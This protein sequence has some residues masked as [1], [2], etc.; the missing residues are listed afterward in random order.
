MK[1]KYNKNSVIERIEIKELLIIKYGSKCSQL[2]GH[3]CGKLFHSFDLTI[4]HI[5]PI[6]RKG[7]DNFEN[8]QLLCNE[9]HY[10]KTYLENIG[11]K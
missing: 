10:T 2:N 11:V 6:N 4:D 1:P 3:G 9:C 8:L 5:K 7:S